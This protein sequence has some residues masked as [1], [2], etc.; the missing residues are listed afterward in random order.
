VQYG[1]GYTME[2]LSQGNY[3]IYCYKKSDSNKLVITFQKF[4]FLKK[5]VYLGWREVFWHFFSYLKCSDEKNRWK[6]NYFL[7]RD[8]LRKN[9]VNCLICERIDLHNFLTE[10][11]PDI[12]STTSWDCLS[13][14]QLF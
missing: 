14:K 9:I 8:D 3:S 7:G 6:I 13:W 12:T 10:I 11:S 1:G 4:I 2:F 5:Y